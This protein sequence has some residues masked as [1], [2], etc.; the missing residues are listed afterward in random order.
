MVLI[1]R[2]QEVP[3]PS[4][5]SPLSLTLFDWLDSLHHAKRYTKLP[6]ETIAGGNV[7]TNYAKDSLPR[8]RRSAFMKVPRSKD[9]HDSQEHN[10]YP[11]TTHG[12][13][14]LTQT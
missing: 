11:A 4:I 6:E 9:E 14:N 5:D 1:D 10:E 8:R 13:E 12:I 2:S 3:D 7:K